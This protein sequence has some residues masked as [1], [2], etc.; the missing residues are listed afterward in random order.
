MLT[1]NVDFERKTKAI[2]KINKAV[3]QAAQEFLSQEP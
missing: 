3:G 1:G 2:V